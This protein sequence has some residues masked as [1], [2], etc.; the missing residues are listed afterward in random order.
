MFMHITSCFY[1]DSYP[2]LNFFKHSLLPLWQKSAVKSGLGMPNERGLDV[3]LADTSSGDY[4]SKWGI[5]DEL[6]NQ[7]LKTLSL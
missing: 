5:H 6:T 3:R 7:I 2:D 1:S 4:V